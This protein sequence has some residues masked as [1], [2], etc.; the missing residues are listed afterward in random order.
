MVFT[1]PKHAITFG[2][3]FVVEDNKDFLIVSG[4]LLVSPI[5]AKLR[6]CCLVVLSQNRLVLLNTITAHTYC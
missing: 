1:F 3:K 2:C 5:V 6:F 4:T